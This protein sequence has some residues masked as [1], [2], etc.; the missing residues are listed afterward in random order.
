ME[1]KGTVR[2]RALI[3]GAAALVTAAAARRATLPA[4]ANDGSP[5]LIGG[6]TFQLAQS[7]TWLAVN[8]DIGNNPALRVQ[9]N[10]GSEVVASFGDGVQGYSASGS[11]TGVYGRNLQFQGVGVWGDA[12]NG[13]ATFGDSG[14]GY[15]VVG[16]S[17]AGTG[18]YGTT[19]SGYGVQGIVAVGASAN[20]IAVF[21]YNEST[22][23]SAHGIIGLANAGHGLIGSSYGDS[24]HAGLVGFAGQNGARAGAFYGDVVVSQNFSVLGNQKVYGSKSAAVKHPDGSYRLLHCMEA[25]EAWFEDFGEARFAAGKAQVKVDPD[26]AAVAD[27]SDYHVFLTE[28]GD[29]HLH[30][31]ERN[32]DHFSVQV[33]AGTG[34]QASGTTGVAPLSGTFSWRIVARRKDV[35]TAR[36]EKTASPSMPALNLPQPNAANSRAPGVPPRRKA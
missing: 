3:A 32:A 10:L 22:D 26:F 1:N 9:N 34:S 27:M 23:P 13:T 17:V 12:P 7:T 28:Y 15:G 2:R 35:K 25:P 19:T 16:R 29:Y 33:T 36:L 6:G 24:S 4:E 5:L 11:G 21:G 31:T 20:S 18:V 30:V 14:S 8:V